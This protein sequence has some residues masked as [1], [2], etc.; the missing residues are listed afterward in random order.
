MVKPGSG[1]SELMASAS[2]EISDLSYNDLVV[3]CS[4]TNDYD[5]NEFYLTFQ[6]I[7]N[8]IRINNHTN[9]LLMNVPSRYDLPNSLFVNKNIS[10]LNRRLQKLVK[11]FPH[12]S[13]LETITEQT[14]PS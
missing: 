12:S 9:I 7:K 2:K 3:I 14:W 8:Y 11:A 4:G 1:S 13:F 6:N 10:I 5:L